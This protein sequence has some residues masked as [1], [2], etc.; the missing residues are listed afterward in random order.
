MTIIASLLFL[1]TVGL[2]LGLGLS[3]A[4]SK[5]AVPMDPRQKAILDALPGVNCGACGM[6]GC[7][8]Y[9]EAIVNE[10]MPVNKCTV[11]GQETADALAAIMG[12]EA[13]DTIKQR[14]Y[15]LCQGDKESCPDRFEYRGIPTCP[16]AHLIGGGHKA[17]TYG[18]LGLGT[19]VEACPFGGIT[20][21]ENGL[22]IIDK[23]LCTT[24]GKC[25]AAC[26]RNIIKILPDD[27]PTIALCSNRD[28]G[29]GIRKLCKL[30]CTGCSLCVKACPED[31]IMMENNLP[32]IDYEKCTGCGACVEKCPTGAMTG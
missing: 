32:V 25:V 18:C 23:D 29:G 14:A 13:G 1:G 28:R 3:I 6:P 24:C 16:A 11:G 5:L 15:V 4:H 21:D 31:A 22:P 17:C 19:C 7:G 2:L 30:G 12:V 10:N 9:A 8:G 20:M 26:P 27:I